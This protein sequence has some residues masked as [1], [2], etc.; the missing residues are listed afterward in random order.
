[1]TLIDQVKNAQE[2]SYDKWFERW[3]KSLNLERGILD[4]A[5]QG[6]TGYRISIKKSYESED[7][8]SKERTYKARRMR[9]SRTVEKLKEKLG[10]GFSVEYAR[11]VQEG[12]V[13]GTIPATRV[14]EF[15]LLYWKG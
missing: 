11:D 3:Y 6:Y 13:F 1:M 5:Q 8:W 4:A 7:N 15:I 9:D 2:E 12:M 14:E 10:E